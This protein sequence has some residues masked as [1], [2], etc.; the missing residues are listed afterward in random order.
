[1]EFIFWEPKPEIDEKS[2]LWFVGEFCFKV[3]GKAELRSEVNWLKIDDKWWSGYMEAMDISSGVLKHVAHIPQLKA[4]SKKTIGLGWILEDLWL[5]LQ[6]TPSVL[7]W[8]EEAR[9][10]KSPRVVSLLMVMTCG[11]FLSHWPVFRELMELRDFQWVALLDWIQSFILK[12]LWGLSGEAGISASARDCTSHYYP[13]SP[14]HVFILQQMNG[15]WLFLIL[16][17]FVHVNFLSDAVRRSF[18]G[19]RVEVGGCHR[20]SSTIFSQ[21]NVIIE[22]FFCIQGLSDLYNGNLM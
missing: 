17:F 19:E 10:Y 16:L 8:L 5:L 14:R 2:S 18:V 7:D 11:H 20:D 15:G 4:W 22:G 1:M 12:E 3:V 13:L 6:K 9:K 21:T